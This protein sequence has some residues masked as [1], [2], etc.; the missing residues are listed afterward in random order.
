MTL[1]YAGLDLALALAL[2]LVACGGR[3]DPPAG[4][5]SAAPA[6]NAEILERLDRL[7]KK[8]DALAA[9]K[10]VPSVA[11][12]AGVAVADAAPAVADAPKPAPVVVRPRTGSGSARMTDN[13]D[14]LAGF[15]GT[16]K[17]PGA[18]SAAIDCSKS[19]LKPSD[20]TC[21][22]QYCKAHPSDARCELLE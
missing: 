6:N 3:S 11:V 8:L 7:E 2:A 10:S 12:D 21:R 20:P 5:S 19:I 4:G 16:K 22:Q 9:P 15:P 18:G 13:A 1:R 14:E 17:I